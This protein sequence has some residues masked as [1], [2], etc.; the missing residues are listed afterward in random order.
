[1]TYLMESP[2]EG[3]RLLAQARTNPARERLVAAGVEPG[4]R[5]LDVGCGP[6]A[7]TLELCELVGT[8]GQVV[9]IDPSPGRLTE[10]RELLA[11]HPNVLLLQAGLPATGLLPRSFDAVHAQ[12]V[13][14]YLGD[15]GPA[16]DAC[17]GLCRPGGR[18]VVSDIDGHGLHAWPVPAAVEAGIATFQAALVRT[19]F[20]L[21]VGR[22]LFSAFVA[23]GL[24]EV[25]VQLTPIDVVAGAADERL[26]ADWRQRFEALAPVGEKAFGSAQSWGEFAAAYLAL[27]SDPAALKYTVMLT[28]SGRTP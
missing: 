23:R 6:G 14:E 12:Y 25:R 5:V 8:R 2:A 26:L 7:V 21:F 4:M 16:L 1:M 19:G 13:F 20:D 17:I 28:T 15:F 24:G 27:L 18:V 10:A 3:R 9:G 22:K 11:G